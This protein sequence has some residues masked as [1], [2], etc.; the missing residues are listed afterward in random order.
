MTIVGVVIGALVLGVVLYFGYAYYQNSQSKVAI[1]TPYKLSPSTATTT[2][3]TT[4]ALST[5][6]QSIDADLSSVDSSL[7]ALDQNNIDIQT[8]LKDTPAAL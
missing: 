5:D 2:A 6:N 1:T 3:S 7:K 8:S 4:P